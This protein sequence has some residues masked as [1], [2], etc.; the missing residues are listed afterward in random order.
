MCAGVV[1]IRLKRGIELH[2]VIHEFRNSMGTGMAT[3]EDKLG[4]KQSRLSHE[5]LFQVFLDVYKDYES[6]NRGRGLDILRGYGLGTNLA[7]LLNHYWERQRIVPKAGKF[8]GKEFGTGKGVTQVYP[9]SPMIFNI[10]VD[11]VMRVVLE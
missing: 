1:N 5:P 11:E 4:E 6:I 2:T 9:A 10:V 3:L 7:R 8:M